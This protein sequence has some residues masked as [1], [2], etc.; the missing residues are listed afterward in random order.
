MRLREGQSGMR[1]QL[2]KELAIVVIV[3]DG[4]MGPVMATTSYS[5]SN[6]LDSIMIV[7]DER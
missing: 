3:V 7:G 1:V 2:A 6:Q 4:C 5:N